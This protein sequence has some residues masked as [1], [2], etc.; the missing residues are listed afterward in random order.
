MV[1]EENVE[2]E[3]DVEVEEEDVEVE[4]EDVE[5]EEEDVDVEEVVVIVVCQKPRQIW[6]AARSAS[7]NNTYQEDRLCTSH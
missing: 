4:E 3:K 6:D 7:T 1:V 5:L 2:V